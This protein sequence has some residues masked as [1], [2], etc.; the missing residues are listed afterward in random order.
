MVATDSF[1]LDLG[2][3]HV[4]QDSLVGYPD[5][6]LEQPFFG[7]G[8]IRCVAAQLG[9][10]LAVWDATRDHLAVSGRVKDPHQ[11]SRLGAIVADLEAAF[12]CVREAYWRVARA[13]AWD[14]A[15]DDPATSLC[16][17]SARAAVEGMSDRICALAVRSV[18]CAGLMES[19]PLSRGVRDLM[20]YLRQ[21]APDAALTRLGTNAGLRDYRPNF[22]AA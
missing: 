4:E 16:A 11:A 10:A 17:D 5:N 3:I 9:G 22:D 1:T 2:G 13:I 18:G 14:A 15:R 20:V 19:H 7:A 6:F 21:P 8:H 12:S